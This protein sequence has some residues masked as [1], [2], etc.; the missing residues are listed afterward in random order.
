LTSGQPTVDAYISAT[1]LNGVVYPILA[2]AD[3]TSILYSTYGD[4]E[5]TVNILPIADLTTAQ[6]NQ[7]FIKFDDDLGIEKMAFYDKEITDEDCL[8]KI[9][10]FSL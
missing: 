5:P 10:K 1:D 2:Q 3:E 4:T 7:L 9:D 8:E 6:N